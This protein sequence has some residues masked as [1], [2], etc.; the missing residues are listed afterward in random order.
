MPA[1]ADGRSDG[2]LA[3]LS[4]KLRTWK[5]YSA[6]FEVEA[7][8]NEISGFYA[9]DGDK[10]YMVTDGYKVI[11][12]GRVRYEINHNDEEV[13]VDYADPDDRNILSNPTRAFEFAGDQFTGVYSQEGELDVVALTPRNGAS[14]LERITLKISRGKGVPVSISYLSEGLSDEVLVTITG[15]GQGYPKDSEFTFDKNRYKGYEVI[16]FR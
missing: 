16:D 14:A 9:V 1:V 2:V 12:D 4:E 13:I 5:S 11:C 10:Y 8:G 15:F 6:S 3:R 7:E